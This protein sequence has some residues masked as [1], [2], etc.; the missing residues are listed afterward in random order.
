MSARKGSQLPK[1]TLSKL[2]KSKFKEKKEESNGDFMEVD[3]LSEV[4]GDPV[5]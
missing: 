3:S 5:A 4:D 1:R 2:R